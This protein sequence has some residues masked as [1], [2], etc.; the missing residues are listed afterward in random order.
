MKAAHSTG[1]THHHL[2]TKSIS[3]REGRVTAPQVDRIVS[4][5]I[6]LTLS[7][8]QSCQPL[9]GFQHGIRP[10]VEVHIEPANAADAEVLE[11]GPRRLSLADAAVEVSATDK[12]ERLL[13]CLGEL[14]L[15]QSTF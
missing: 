7:E 5:T 3:S 1:L 13:A 4:F 6:S 9:R 12:G 8:D 11:R 14:H 15:E 10:L 2:T